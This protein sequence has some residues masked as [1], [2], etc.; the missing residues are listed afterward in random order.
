MFKNKKRQYLK[1][2]IEE[3]DENFQNSNVR[4]MYVGNNFRKGLQARTEIVKDENNNLIIDSTGVLNVWKNY[5]DRLLNVEFD[6]DREI[7]SGCLEIHTAES[8]INKPTISEVKS[9]IKD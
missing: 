7:E 1:R 5:F 3:I 6:N 9:A 4:G 8:V 2:K